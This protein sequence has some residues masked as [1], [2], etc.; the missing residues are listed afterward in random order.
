[1]LTGSEIQQES[2]FSGSNNEG[3]SERKE[4]YQSSELAGTTKGQMTYFCTVTSLNPVQEETVV[5]SATN[6][7]NELNLQKEIRYSMKHAHISPCLK[8]DIIDDSFHPAKNMLACIFR[9]E[10]FN[11][12]GDKAQQNGNPERC[13]SEANGHENSENMLDKSLHSNKLETTQNK[14]MQLKFNEKCQNAHW[15]SSDTSNNVSSNH[16][17]FSQI[18]KPQITDTF[19]MTRFS[20]HSNK[21]QKK[22]HGQLLR[23][24]TARINKRNCKGETRLH[25][26]AGKGDLSLVKS[27]IASGACV[28]LKD[29]AGIFN[30]N[31]LLCCWTAIHEASIRGF[32]E[33]IAE[34]LKAGA[35]VNSKSL[36]GVLPIHDAV[37]GNH[38]EAVQFLLLH[39]ANPNERDI[40]GG[41][42]LDEATCDKMKELLK[43]Y[44]ATKTKEIPSVSDVVDCYI[45][46]L[47][48]IQK[49]LNAV[50]AKQKS[51]RDG[52][53]KKYRASVESF[54]QG[55]LREQLVKLV[56]RQKRL[57]LMA[58]K[59]KELGWKIKNYKT[60]RKQFSSSAKEMSKNVLGYCERS[61]TKHDTYHKTVPCPDVVKTSLV[62]GFLDEEPS[63]YQDRCINI[64]IGNGEAIGE[65]EIDLQN[66]V[67][68]SM[69]KEYNTQELVNSKCSNAVDQAILPSEPSI[70]HMQQSHLMEIDGIPVA[71]QRNKPLNA[72]SQIC[73]PNDS[74]T[75]ST[76][77]NNNSSQPVTESQQVCTNDSLQQRSNRNEAFQ[78]QPESACYYTTQKKHFPKNRISFTANLEPARIFSK[79]KNTQTASDSAKQL[80]FRTNRRKKSQLVDLIEQGK[81]KPGNDVLEFMLQDSKH[82]A[83]LLEHGKVK[84][85][86]NSVYQNPVQWIKALLGND[87]T[88]SWRYVCNKVRYCGT[89]LSEIIG[90]V[91][92]PQGP[93]L[94]LQQKNLPGTNSAKCDY[95][96]GGEHSSFSHNTSSFQDI[97]NI[98][99]EAAPFFQEDGKIPLFPE[100]EAEEMPSSVCEI[101]PSSQSTPIKAPR[102][103]LQFN[104]IV[105]IQ[106]EEFLPC[107]TMEQYW[108]FYV[109]CENFGFKTTS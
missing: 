44:G 72:T 23:T 13:C 103:F 58:Q 62:M 50:L 45:Q 95:N 4:A 68:E 27:L 15:C 78:M 79:S 59:Q 105:L 9:E 106:D 99:Q 93:E 64:P 39:G 83:S 22:A 80:N 89:L 51:E 56:S 48:Q 34:L 60:S 38:F 66:L 30:L 35:D 71:Q 28:N 76:G 67:G 18:E 63:Q 52:L 2:D 55:T 16:S 29:N 32:T 57:L 20:S 107:H 36:D 41:T 31:S 97:D 109:H 43:S 42:A 10:S 3:S 19:A 46:D 70:S 33:I 88:V 54:K 69:L 108:D 77:I 21:K 8:V 86:N 104:K 24:T 90:E 49:T 11:P 5:P 37:S 96:K 85:G 17:Q 98:Q 53:A 1:M 82:K 25:L 75:G 91:H 26:A 94:L 92:V 47:S 100:T 14:T 65:K 74:E 102:R 6:L 40:C 73:T 84:T 101:K 61:N 12:S 81:L 7:L 87:I